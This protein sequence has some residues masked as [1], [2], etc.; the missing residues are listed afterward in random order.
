MINWENRYKR[1]LAR[2]LFSWFLVVLLCLACYLLFGYI[3]FRQSQLNSDYNY[4]IDCNVLFPGVNFDTY[5]TSLAASGGN[6][7]LTCYC[8]GKSL[9]SVVSG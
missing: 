7:Y 9:T 3:Q 1:T 6:N 2:A 4:K 8:Q 5:S